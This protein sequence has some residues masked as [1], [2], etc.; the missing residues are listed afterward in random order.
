MHLPATF[1]GTVIAGSGRGQALGFPTLNLMVPAAVRP[2]D[3]GVYAGWAR[4]LGAWVPSVA[5]LGPA[6][7]FGEKT[8]MLEIH[9]LDWSGAWV[10]ASITVQLVKKIR[11]TKKFPQPA[12]LAAQIRDDCAAARQI[13]QPLNLPPNSV[14]AA[15]GSRRDSPL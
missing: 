6:S 2:N 3:W 8:P 12:D 14:G 11:N 7:T 4:V 5:H 1:R 15:A 9:V 13:L 10:D